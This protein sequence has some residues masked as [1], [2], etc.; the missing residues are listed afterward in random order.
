MSLVMGNRRVCMPY[1]DTTGQVTGTAMAMLALV[2]YVAIFAIKRRRDRRDPPPSPRDVDV[3]APTIADDDDDDDRDRR[4]WYIFSLDLTKIALSQ[5]V[6][7]LVNLVFSVVDTTW[8]ARGNHDGGDHRQGIALFADVFILDA[9]VGVPLGLA[10]GTRFTHWCF[11]NHHRNRSTSMESTR[12][13]NVA[14]YSSS[15][16]ASDFI[17]ANAEYGR[18]F[19]ASESSDE[20]DAAP[21]MSNDKVRCSWWWW[22]LLSWSG[23]VAVSRIAAGLVVPLSVALLGEGTQ[24]LPIGNTEHGLST[25]PAL[26]V[27]DLVTA[28]DASCPTKQFAVI[29]LLRFVVDLLQVA[30]I[31]MWNRWRPPVRRDDHVV[32]EKAATTGIAAAPG[33]RTALWQPAASYGS[34][35]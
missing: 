4:S 35:S 2:V 13:G 34:A 30:V 1:T 14:S 22:Q 16:C 23:I 26:W 11:V 10:L 6:A 7:W 24:W 25:N 9:L 29:G 32:K 33:P 8:L 12:G 5:S 18:Y 15:G 3:R 17:H 20:D 27:A 21:E 19:P 31:D 28:W